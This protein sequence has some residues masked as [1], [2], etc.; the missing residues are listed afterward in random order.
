MNR[1][2]AGLVLLVAACGQEPTVIDG[3]TAEAFAETTAQARRDLPDADRLDFDSALKNPPGKRYG[4]TNSEIEA[5]AR[6]L[7]DG[8]TARQVVDDFGA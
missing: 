7:Y 4:D 6:E 1:L 2:G 5:L 8:K 3:S